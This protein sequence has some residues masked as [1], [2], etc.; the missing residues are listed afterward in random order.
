[1]PARHLYVHVPFCARRCAYCD[2]SVAVRRVVPVDDYLR[3]LEA[4]LSALSPQAWVDPLDTVYLGGGTPSR[5]GTAGIARLMATLRRYVRIDPAAEITLEANPDDTDEESVAA[6]AAAGVNRLS[7]GVQSFDDAVLRWMHRAHNSS[8]AIDAV[9]AARAGGI[10]NVS[11]DLIFALPREISRS[12]GND[13][14]DALDLSPK[15]ISL[16]GLTVEP[17]TPLARWTERGAVAHASDD[18]YAEEFLLADKMARERGFVHYEVSSFA[19]PGHES[20]HNA[21]YWNGSPYVGIG[22]SAHSFDGVIRSWNTRAYTAWLAR[23]DSGQSPRDTAE[24]LTDE[25]R[26]AEGIYLGLRTA[27]GYTAGEADLG[28]ARSWQHAGWAEIGNDR[29]TLTPEGWL[30]LDA[31]ASRLTGF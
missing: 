2:F 3:G 8:Q 17:L 25:N 16:Y 23:L 14:R 1:M 6:W 4:E 18:L 19:L 31:L 24:R 30:R 28:R 29:I 12:W 20:R 27:R 22:P 9:H 11:I 26:A 13:L 5:L 10:V 21:A 15:H 7:I